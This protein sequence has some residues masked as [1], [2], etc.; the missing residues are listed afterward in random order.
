[1]VGECGERLPGPDKNVRAVKCHHGG[2][3]LFVLF[4]LAGNS[5]CTHQAGYRF[6]QNLGESRQMCEERRTFAQQEY[7][8]APY[9]TSFQTYQQQRR[10]VIGRDQATD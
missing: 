3:L 6:V 9:Q 7:C 10:Q 1:M 4:A 2:Y 5:A 8:A